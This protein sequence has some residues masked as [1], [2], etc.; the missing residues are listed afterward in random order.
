M[1]FWT[2]NLISDAARSGEH[3]VVFDDQ[4]NLDDS[5]ELLAA[6]ETPGVGFQHHQSHGSHHRN[7]IYEKKQRNT[8]TGV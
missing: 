6:A 2:E 8:K 1:H 4:D 7:W 5:D 3:R